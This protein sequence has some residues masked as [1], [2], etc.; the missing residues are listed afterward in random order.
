M[1]RRHLPRTVDAAPDGRIQGAHIT[2]GWL[3]ETAGYTWPTADQVI[4]AAQVEAA[5]AIANAAITAERQRITTALDALTEKLEWDGGVDSWEEALNALKDAH[6][7]VNPQEQPAPGH[8]RALPD[9][10]TAYTCGPC[11]TNIAVAHETTHNAIFHTAEGA[12]R[13]PGPT[14]RARNTELEQP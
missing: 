2:R 6:A 4:T 11:G 5:T 9:T 10:F 12:S 14:P 13:D 8:L 1:S 7:I 3:D